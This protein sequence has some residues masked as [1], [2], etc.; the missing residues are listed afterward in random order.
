M[1]VCSEK[2]GGVARLAQDF[3]HPTPTRLEEIQTKVASLGLSLPL[4]FG[5]RGAS[6]SPGLQARPVF[7]DEAD[8]KTKAGEIGSRNR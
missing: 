4:S 7:A 5:H 1:W 8:D 6:I 2:Q 3:Q